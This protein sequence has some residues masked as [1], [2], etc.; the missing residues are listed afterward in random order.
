M[1][2]NANVTTG[3]IDTTTLNSALTLALE[4]IDEIPDIRSSIGSDRGTLE[5][6]KSR[7]EDFLITTT[8]AVSNIE[9]V[10]VVEIVSRM[11]AQ[12]TQLEASYTLTARLGQLSLVNF[13][14]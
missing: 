1:A 2:K 5:T 12:Q 14:R 9:D 4:A 3:N 13:L 11:A 10:D 7:H 6:T 8:E